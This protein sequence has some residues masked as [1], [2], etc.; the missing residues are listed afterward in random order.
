MQENKHSEIH[1]ITNKH[2]QTHPTYTNVTTFRIN[3]QHPP[4][5]KT[6]ILRHCVKTFV[7]TFVPQNTASHSLRYQS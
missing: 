2:T 6:M 5:E 1:S 4:S 3:V 7:R